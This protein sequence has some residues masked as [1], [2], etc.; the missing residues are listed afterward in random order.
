MSNCHVT[1]LNHFWTGSAYLKRPQ[2]KFKLIFATSIKLQQSICLNLS[3]NLS[4][5]HIRTVS[6]HINLLTNPAT[7]AKTLLNYIR[8]LSQM[9]WTLYCEYNT[10]IKFEP[11]PNRFNVAITNLKQILIK[12]FCCTY[13]TAVVNLFNTLNPF[14][15]RFANLFDPAWKPRCLVAWSCSSLVKS[16]LIGI[17]VI[18]VVYT[19]FACF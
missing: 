8:S 16:T 10:K 14:L 12:L 15:N 4:P 6:E 18:S 7:N 11:L 19:N 2:S 1:L 17:F 5:N 3:K 9:N 13:Q